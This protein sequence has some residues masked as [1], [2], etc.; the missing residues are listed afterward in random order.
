MQILQ[1]TLLTFNHANFEDG[2][3]FWCGFISSPDLLF[4]GHLGYAEI[5]QFLILNLH[6]NL[7]AGNLV[8][9]VL[10]LG[11]GRL[12]TEENGWV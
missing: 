5:M 10:V 7:H 9:Q 2:T 6:D 8:R 1:G 12:R 3:L 11:D 4:E